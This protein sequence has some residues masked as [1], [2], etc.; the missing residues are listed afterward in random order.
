MDISR[1][2]GHVAPTSMCIIQRQLHLSTLSVHTADEHT[3]LD[4]AHYKK[5][6]RSFCHGCQRAPSGILRTEYHSCSA[7]PVCVFTRKCKR[8]ASMKRNIK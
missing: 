3:L 1:G 8:A 7:I 4:A 5:A 6:T 2:Y